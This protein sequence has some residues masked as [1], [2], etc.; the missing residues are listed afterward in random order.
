M[1]APLPCIEPP[2]MV[3]SEFDWGGSTGQVC[4]TKA[5]VMLWWLKPSLM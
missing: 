3:V 1:L 4:V 2:I 5:E